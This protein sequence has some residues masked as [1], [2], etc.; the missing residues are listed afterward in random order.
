M[1]LSTEL[2]PSKR[3]PVSTLV[4][5]IALAL[6]FTTASYTA[7]QTPATLAAPAGQA[8]AQTT[9]GAVV[10]GT[11]TDPDDELVPGAAITL[12]PNSG[13]PYT[14]TSGSDGAYTLR[15][16]PPGTYNLTVTM[17]GFATFVKPGVKIAANGATVNA[18]M[19]IQ[20]DEVVNV[21]STQAMV[22][23]DQDSNASA[24]IL[25]GAALDALSDDPDELQSELEALAGP[26]S[27]P[28]GGQIYID[29]F[30]GGQLPPK[31]SIR[32]IR[33]NQ[34][35]FSAQYDRAGFGRIEIFTK[36]GTDKFHGNINLQGNDRVF[37]TGS[38]FIPAGT[39]QPDYHTIFFNGNITGPI[40]KKA[41]FSGGGSY[42]VIQDNEVVNPPAVYATSQ[43]SGVI[44]APGQAGCNIYQ[45]ATGNGYTFVQFEPQTRWDSNIKLDLQL[46][47]KNTLTTRVQYYHNSAQYQGIGGLSLPIGGD[48]TLGTEFT[49]Q[50]VDTQILSAKVINETRFEYQRPTSVATPFN[51]SPAIEVQGAFSGGGSNSGS[52]NDFQNHLEFQNYTSIALAKNF[53]R[54]GGRLRTTSDN[55]TSTAGNNGDFV[56]NSIASY[57]AGNPATTFSLTVIPTPTVQVRTTDLG[58]Y[59]EDDWKVK[60]NWTFSYGI[61]F[62]TQNYI[63][64]KADFAPRLST[65]YGLTKKTVIRSG[66]GIFY[67]RFMLGNQ[68]AVARNNGINQ[69]QVLVTGTNL[70][71]YPSCTPTNLAACPTP[72]TAPTVRTTT[73]T[74]APNL[75][76]PY[77]LQFNVGVDQQMSKFGTISVNYNHIRGDHQFVDEIANY[78]SPTAN[79]PL[80]YQYQSEADFNQN[81]LIT[82]VN[83]RGIKRVTLFGYYVLNFAKSDTAGI[84]SF[85]S[86]PNNIKADYGRASF[87]VRNRIF[88]GGNITL[89]YLI[90]LAP[91]LVA[92]SGAPYNITSGTDPYG[93]GQYNYRAALVP[94]G[95]VP[96]TCTSSS[97]ANCQYVKTIN[98]C[99]TFATPGTAGFNTPAPINDCTGPGSFSTNLRVTKTFGFGPQRD[100]NPARQARQQSGGAP[101][102]PGGMGG[103]GGGR[104][105]GGG[106]GG[107][108]GGGVNSG[109]RY[110]LGIGAQ[111]SNIFNIADRGS[112]VGTL[113][114]P[115]FGTSTA[116]VGGL[117]T[118]NSAIRRIQL[119]ASFTF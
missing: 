16:V 10:K 90:S 41:S 74:I 84:G 13:K 87:D 66:F 22:S 28:N 68:L 29:G 92:N 78:I 4:R 51:T 59:A 89:P 69:Q 18:K 71:L 25:T 27:G 8:A 70:A 15:G 52:S 97:S 83:I 20:A 9:T 95:T 17:A 76:A 118:T 58:L 96:A 14:T 30:T 7:A 79:N 12:A 46:A 23:V 91:L 37:N 33:I 82:N 116:L 73:D 93:I 60:P 111:F 32:E 77:T 102:P 101:P 64:D 103:G 40:N 75:R 67:D 112:P 2:S 54:L 110:N 81:Q 88:I 65:A 61:R 55:N 113:T 109:K 114:S 119:Q 53:I 98:G 108:G 31:S 57:A 21:T 42:R 80:Q 36:P 94:A 39:F 44:C 85:S 99:G 43:T 5:S 11:I 105:G 62:E 117:F 6:T 104:G 56:Y 38:V 100:A 1:S 45:T 107:M 24:T 35:P 106:G 3:F 26:S 86:T 48:N 72:A 50:A 63:H 47:P 49:I 115:S 34:N 19:S